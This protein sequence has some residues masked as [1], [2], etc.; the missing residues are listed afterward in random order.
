MT[1]AAVTAI[2]SAVS[3]DTVVVGIGA[4]A[5]AVAVVLVAAKGASLLLQRLR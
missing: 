5:A 3:F 2:T 4:I 1:E